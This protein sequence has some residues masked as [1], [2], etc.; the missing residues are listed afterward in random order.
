MFKTYGEGIF[1]EY[2]TSLYDMGKAFGSLIKNELNFELAIE[3]NSNIVCFRYVEAG[4]NLNELNK[5]NQKIRQKLLEDGTFYIVKTQLRG[6]HYLRCTVMNPFTK[7]E[8]FKNLLS[9][10]LSVKNCISTV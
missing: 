5:L 9:E 3:P 6:V 8:N 1:D 7:E 10:I 2:L 4:A